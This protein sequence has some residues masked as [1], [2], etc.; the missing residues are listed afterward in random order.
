MAPSE[1][2]QTE[3]GSPRSGEPVYL[4]V[5]KLHRPHGL[6]GE[7]VMEVLTDFPER[8]RPKK[9]VFI[10]DNHQA[11]QISQVRVHGRGL[12]VKFQGIDKPDSALHLVNQM[13]YVPMESIPSLPSG[14][15]YFHQ[16][17]GLKVIDREDHPLGFLEEIIE[18]GANDVYIIRNENGSEILLPALESVILE[19][20]LDRKIMRVNPP[21]W[22]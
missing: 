16:L 6:R 19:V 9:T 21:D 2:E 11:A 3:S 10:G 18:T 12:L 8:L 7:I 14:E 22:A 17:V 15:Y 4:V 5:G 13:V 1:F 20:D